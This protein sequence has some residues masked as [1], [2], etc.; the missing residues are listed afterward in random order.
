MAGRDQSFRLRRIAAQHPRLLAASSAAAVAGL[1]VTQRLLAQR[2]SERS[3]K[4]RRRYRI[5]PEAD[6]GPELRRV[7]SAQLDIALEGLNGHP[8]E[9]EGIH[10]ARKALKRGRTL[11]RVSR[12]ILGRDVFQ[13]ENRALRDAG[14]A[15]SDARDSEVLAET[16]RS[17]ASDGQ[18]A[19]PAGALERL[20][21]AVEPQPDP[22]AEAGA[23]QA[24][25]AVAETSSRVPAWPLP[26]PGEAAPVGPGIK[27]IYRQ[28]RQAVRQLRKTPDDEHWHELRKRSK[29]LW[30][31][32]QLLEASHPK[33]MRKLAKRAHR[34]SSLLGD[35][36]DLAVLHDRVRDHP[37]ELE[38]GDLKLIGG[39][40]DSRRGK[41]QRKASRLAKRLYRRKPGKFVRRLGLG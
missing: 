36:H 21:N 14:R 22:D 24:R 40:I 6:T 39:L 15:L 12:Y 30:H 16:A 28:G 10:D 20:R 26:G 25:S 38:P 11:L 27:R 4:E 1:S 9:P 19:L 33:R 8:P 5:A 7:A 17:L 37:A 23:A 18:D 29:D 13:R 31:G 2:A 41:L 32:A 35:D 3:S 34:L